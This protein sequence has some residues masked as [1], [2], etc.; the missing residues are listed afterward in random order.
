MKIKFFCPYWGSEHFS[1]AEFFSKVVQAGYQGVEY[2]IAKD[3]EPKTIEKFFEDAKKNSLE[4]I[5]QHYDTVESK[6]EK[7]CE[8]YKAWFEKIE[9]YDCVL[10]NSQTGKDYY[11]FEQNDRLFRIAK[12]FE[13]KTGV[14]VLHETH[15]GKFSFAAH[16]TESYLKKNKDLRLTL[17]IS[18]WINV[19]ESY[20]EDQ[21]EAVDLA[22]SRTDHIHARVG[23]KEGPQVNDPSAPEWSISLEKHLNW[24]NKVIK[25]R[26]S[27]GCEFT[28]ITPEFGPVPYMPSLPYSKKPVAD[29]WKVNLF[30]VEYF[31]NIYE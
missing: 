3:A 17:D 27:E 25:R 8:S 19:A 4:I 16:I 29:Q 30:M 20:L 1:N 15:R 28:T 9:N 12:T 26:S 24:W 18:H 21:Q 2:A 31:R 14:A 13:S 22:I 6:F 23:F 11:S 7:H 5:L 10:I